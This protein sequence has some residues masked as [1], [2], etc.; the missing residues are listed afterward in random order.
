MAHMW[1][2]Q[3]RAKKTPGKTWRLRRPRDRFARQ[4]YAGAKH[5]E[6]NVESSEG[7]TP[8]LLRFSPQQSSDV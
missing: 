7:A 1:Q 8:E 5:C 2:P 4:S 6:T 3:L